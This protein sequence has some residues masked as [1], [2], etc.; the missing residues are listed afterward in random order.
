MNGSDLDPTFGRALQ[1]QSRRNGDGKLNPF[2]SLGG[3]L[4]K[5]LPGN[6]QFRADSQVGKGWQGVAGWQMKEIVLFSH[7]LL[8]IYILRFL[9]YIV[10]S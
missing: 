2:H 8:P 7:W 9:E 5:E 6:W 3:S 4:K 10:T 1:V